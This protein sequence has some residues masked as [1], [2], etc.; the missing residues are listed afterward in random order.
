[1]IA[2]E[3]LRRIPPLDPA[4]VAGRGSVRE[5]LARRIAADPEPTRLRVTASDDWMLVLGRPEDLPWVDG[6]AYLGWDHGILLP[7][8]RRPSIPVELLA[9]NLRRTQPT[10]LVALLPTGILTSVMPTRPVDVAR[11]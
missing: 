10:E 3:W 4:A 7:T 5:A 8:T 2:W 6:A 9:R 11:L 1:M